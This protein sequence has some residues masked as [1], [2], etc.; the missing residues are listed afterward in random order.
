MA[1]LTILACQIRVPPV[2]SGVDRD[3]HLD[4]VAAEIR[5]HLRR[6]QYDLVVLP[7]LSSIDYSAASFDNLD[8]LAEPL[9]GPSHQRFGPLAREFGVTVVYG[10][11]RREDQAYFVSQVIVDGGGEPLGYFDKLHLAQYGASMEKDYFERGKHIF[12]F[13]VQGIRIAPIICYDIRIPE[14]T[15]TLAVEQGVQLVLHCSA[16]ARDESFYSWHHFSV[17]R[18]VEN[19]IYFLSLNRAGEKYGN[20]IFCTP[21]VDQNSPGIRFPETAEKFETIEIETDLIDNIR[22]EYPLLYDRLGNYSTLPNLNDN[23]FLE[24]YRKS[25]KNS[26]DLEPKP[27]KLLN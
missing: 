26:G 18:A 2:A 17:C 24:D 16:H 23:P 11:P 10:I 21:W 13:E 27:L 6:R 5:S 9:D 20:S 12:I 1:T 25:A 14:L 3:R 4:R 22:K 7:E 19:Q 8:V 15:R